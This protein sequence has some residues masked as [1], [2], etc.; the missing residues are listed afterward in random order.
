LGI[1]L[2]ETPPTGSLKHLFRPLLPRNRRGHEGQEGCFYGFQFIICAFVLLLV[3]AKADP[4]IVGNFIWHDYNRDGAQDGGE[5]GVPDIVV[6]LWNSTKSQ[7]LDSATTNSNGSYTL[8]APAAG[9]YRL[10]VVLPN[11]HVSFSPKNQAAG[12]DL[13]DSDVNPIGADVGFTDVYNFASNLISIT[14]LDAGLVSDVIIGH[15]IGNRVFRANA[16]GTQPDSPTASVGGSVTVYLL[17]SAGSILQTTSS[18]ANVGILGYYSFNAPPGTYRL[19]FESSSFQIPTRFPNAGGD[20]S[21]DSDI[22][23]AGETPLFTIAAGQVR[24]DLDAGFVN[25]VSVGNLVWRDQDSDGVRDAGEPGVPDV[26]LELWDTAKTN[27]FDVTTTDANG[28]YSLQ[29]P[30]PGSYRVWVLRPLATDLF[31]PIDTGSDDIVDSDIS[32]SDSNF[33]F[34]NTY[35]FASNLISI[36]TID[37]GLIFNPAGRTIPELRVSAFNIASLTFRGPTGGTYLVERSANLATWSAEGSP[38][39]TASNPT[40]RFL[41][42]LP[43]NTPAGFWRVRRTK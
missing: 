15:T 42:A 27:R 19:R 31:S 1:F 23:A 5:P 17:N 18:S 16:D 39:I 30:G 28:I 22:D 11:N 33:G 3:P 34:T 24:T 13:L 8:R 10:R 37:A 20:A 38:F 4:I 41:P 36:N 40:T 35:N 14:T 25:L 43:A 7:I 32:S 2:T 9:S 29:A 21:L 26:L 12:S 6:Q